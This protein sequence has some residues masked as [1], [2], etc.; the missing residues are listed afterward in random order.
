V[1]KTG[2]RKFIRTK[3]EQEANSFLSDKG[4]YYLCTVATGGEE[5]EVEA[6]THEGFPVR[7]AE[8]DA[9]IVGADEVFSVKKDDKAKK[10]GK[11]K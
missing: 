7:T 8:E 11:K 3:L 9:A 5:E 10:G 2:E 6:L 1:D 4:V